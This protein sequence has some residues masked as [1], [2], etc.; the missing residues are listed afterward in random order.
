MGDGLY[1]EIESRLGRLEGSVGDGA[2]LVDLDGLIEELGVEVFD[3]LHGH[4]E[5]FDQRHDLVTG[6]VPTL[7]RLEEVL[8]VHDLADVDGGNVV[9]SLHGLLLS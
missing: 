4:V 5:L 3:L 9:F 1:G 8:N 6:D 2:L 7:A